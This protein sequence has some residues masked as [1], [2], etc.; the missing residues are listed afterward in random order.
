MTA[1]GKSAQPKQPRRTKG[2]RVLSYEKALAVARRAFI[3]GFNVDMPS[4]AQSLNVGR[5]TLY[6]VVH[7]RDRLLGDVIWS[8]GEKTLA[9][10]LAETSGTGPERIISLARRFNEYVVEFEPLRA[11][12]RLDPMTAVRVLFTPA[13]DVHRRFVEAWKEIFEGAVERGELTLPF[14]TD[15][16]A[17]VFVRIGESILYSDLL[18]DREPDIELASLVQRALL[19]K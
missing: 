7:S 2:V 1:A 8:F 19:T 5:A 15:D 16:F 10:S 9:M 13:G 3:Q 6:R 4:L 18:A 12:V 14:G 11:F 17:Y